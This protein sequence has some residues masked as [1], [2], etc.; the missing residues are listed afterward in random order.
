MADL[1]E[2]FAKMNSGEVAAH[3]ELGT[4]DE[5]KQMKG[6]GSRIR[7]LKPVVGIKAHVLIMKD[8]VIPFNPFTCESDNTYNHKTPFRPILLVSQVLQGIKDMCASNPELAAKWN[9]AL[10]TDKIDWNAPVCMDD[11]FAFKARDFIKPRVMSYSTVPISMGG[12]GGFSEF[13]QKFTVDP[14]ELDEN[15]NYGFDNAP[16]WHK[17]A[18]FF[19]S[20]LKPEADAVVA[21]L[22]KQG[23]NKE[24]ISTQRRGVYSKS[25]IGFVSQTNLM[26]FLFFPVDE[27]PKEISAEHFM[28]IEKNMR[29][30]TK[31][32]DKFGGA[33]DEAMKDNTFD[34]NMD[35]FDMTLKTPSASQQKSNGQVYTDEDSL[36]LYTAMTVT[37]TDARLSIWSGKTT[38]DNKS[39]DN[40]ELYKSIWDA[41]AAYF[42]YSQEQSGKDG[43]DTFEK[44]MSQSNGFRP[45]TSIIDK[46]L[47]ALNQVFLTQFASSKY[48]TE[49]IKKANSEFF[50]A[51]NPQNAMALADADDEELDDAAKKQAESLAA[52]VADARE[53][54]IPAVEELEL[55]EE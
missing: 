6:Y 32:D 50:I 23:A 30:M 16:V 22:E 35:F 28:D 26:P 4:R 15:N 54:G 27:A 14:R 12:V 36:E 46:L 29:Y 13:R 1:K 44:L 24:T 19:N 5:A 7:K 51:M 20:I 31:N 38:V 39:M 40:S 45:I 53:D 47:P 18:I 43:G 33:L 8:V 42:M 49:D 10:G 25:P 21:A 37:N 11:Y 34:E 52:L 41:A 3:S 9:K 48:F 55:T 2:I 17:G